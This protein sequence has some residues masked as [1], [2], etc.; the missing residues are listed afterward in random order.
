M[1]IDWKDFEKVDMRIGTIIKV[2]DFPKAK[3]PAYQLTIDFGSIGV[4][5]SSAQITNYSKDELNGMKVVAVVNFP[6]KQVADF[7]SEVLVLGALTDE[8]VILLTPSKKE[9]AKPGDRIA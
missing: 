1:E 5:R 2:D 8:G 6:P 9:S 7:I 3:K 4:K